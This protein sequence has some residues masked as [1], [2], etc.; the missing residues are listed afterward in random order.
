MDLY[1]IYHQQ[2]HIENLPDLQPWGHN[3]HSIGWKSTHHSRMCRD[4]CEIHHNFYIVSL[5]Q[6]LWLSSSAWS[7]KTDHHFIQKGD[8]HSKIFKSSL[9][10]DTHAMPQS[11]YFETWI[12]LIKSPG[13]TTLKILH[14]LWIIM[15]MKLNMMIMTNFVMIKNF[16]DGNWQ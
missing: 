8:A 13:I 7:V 4:I 10:N 11:T 2:D 12:S 1:I 16:S 6:L 14:P 9:S 5:R 15:I 3:I